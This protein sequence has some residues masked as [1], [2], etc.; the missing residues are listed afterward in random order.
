M[1]LLTESVY[2]FFS[3]AAL[4]LPWRSLRIGDDRVLGHRSTNWS[5]NE[6]GAPAAIPGSHDIIMRTP[7]AIVLDPDPRPVPE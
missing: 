1:N 7:P 3:L 5:I 4:M 2:V 6:R